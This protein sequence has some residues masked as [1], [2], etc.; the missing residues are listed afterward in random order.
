MFAIEESKKIWSAILYG[1]LAIFIFAIISSLIFS[2]ILRFSSL[3]ESS[4]Q[5]VITAISFIAL[6][7]GG[8]IAGGKGEQKGWLLGGLTGV[9]Y[10]VIIF[11]YQFLGLEKLFTIEQIIYYVCYILI[12]IMGGILRVNTSGK[13]RTT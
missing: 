6:F 4:V 3:Q 5:Y 1:T 7:V 13:S 10:T 12:C 11:L 2:F 8:Y 9:I